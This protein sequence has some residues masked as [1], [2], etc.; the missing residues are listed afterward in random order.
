MK[1]ELEKNVIINGDSIEVMKQMSRKKIVVDLILTDPPYNVSRKHQ[2]GFSNMG[3]AGMNY[4]DWDF[5][6]NQTKWLRI[7]TKLVAENGSIIIFNDW[8]NMGDI[9][10]EL[11]KLG[12]EIKDLLR[13]EK[14]NP[15]P[16][17]VN[18][19]Y[20]S[21]VEY[22]IWAVRKGSKWT[23]NKGANDSY[24]KPSTKVAVM[25]GGSKNKIHP[26][27]KPEA[28]LERIIEIHSNPDD[29]ILDPFSGS[30]STGIASLRKNRKF[31]LIEREKKYYEKSK[32]RFS[33]ISTSL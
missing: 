4:G 15:M 25:A 27:Q 29:I 3:R 16:R 20:V 28:L 21:D 19:R 6:F 23:F 7:A 14:T 11:M 1:K 22:A 31:I 12:F 32:D 26:T 17:N 9:A 13:W 30:G 5:E 8:K 33:E 10:A 24:L 2:L 18:R